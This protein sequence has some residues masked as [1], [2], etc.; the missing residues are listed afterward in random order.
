[1]S[2]VLAVDIEAFE[3]HLI[4]SEGASLIAHDKL[5]LAQLF[6]EV[7]R[8]NL[9]VLPPAAAQLVPGQ[10]FALA[11]SNQFD[12]DQQTDGDEGSKSKKPAAPGDQS[13]NEHIVVL[14]EITFVIFL[15]PVNY[16]IGQC[17]NSGFLYL[18]RVTVS[19]KTKMRLK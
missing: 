7:A 12:C 14:G 5:N 13:G 16:A 1:M 10:N 18:S 4:L 19:W 15:N 17:A 3:I 8:L 11:K 2:E 6:I 9:G